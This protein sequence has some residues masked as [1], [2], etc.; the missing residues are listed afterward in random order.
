[1]AI[2]KSFVRWVKP[3]RLPSVDKITN[4]SDRSMRR[5]RLEA[6]LVTLRVEKHTIYNR[7]PGE[8]WASLGC[9]STGPIWQDKQIV[10]RMERYASACSLQATLT[11]LVCLRSHP[12]DGVTD[13]SDR[14]TEVFWY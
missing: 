10:I 7:L 3:E 4:F 13:E 6:P 12:E 11:L 14:H 8:T 5:I 2:L 1:M 9:K